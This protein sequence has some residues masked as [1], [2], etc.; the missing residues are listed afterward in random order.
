MADLATGGAQLVW[1]AP[2]CPFRIEYSARVLDDIRLAVVDAFF[3]LPRGGAEIGGILLGRHEPDRLII[4]SYQPIECEH[5]T[6]PSFTLSR[7]DEAKLREQLVSA[8]GEVLGWYHSHTRSE[9]FLSD[10]DLEVHKRFF[11]EAWQI[12]IVMKPHTFQPMRVGIF[13]QERDGTIQASAPYS[14][15][16]LEPLPIRQVP[17]GEPPFQPP[18][19][20]P[21]RIEPEGRGPAGPI[22]DLALPKEEPARVEPVGRPVLV[23]PPEPPPPMPVAPIPVTAAPPPPTPVPPTPVPPIPVPPTAA[24]PIPVPPEPVIAAPAEVAPPPETAAAVIPPPSFLTTQPEPGH[25]PRWLALLAILA[26]L[27]LGGVGYLTHEAWWPRV[28]KSVK[29]ALPAS[30]PPPTFGLNTLDTNGQLQIHWDQGSAATR[31]GTAA[32]LTITDGSQQPVSTPLDPQHLQAGTFTYA[33]QAGKVEVKMTIRLPDGRDA[34]EATTFLGAMPVVQPPP[35]DP[36]VR[37]Q[38]DELA[39]QAQKLKSDLAAQER[40]TKKLE[41]SLTDVQRTLRQEQLRRMQNQAP[42]K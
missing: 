29:S 30:A 8:R 35:E 19:G 41:R 39:A 14:E 40:R 24:A 20:S 16:L 15:M 5:A 12:A 31:T 18:I 10:A 2:Q 13:F 21:F 34:T 9:L 32:T 36:E 37:R 23:K 22:I 26:G 42:P 25:A 27:A 3:S 17:S 33:R 7:N 11:P 6:G 1:E 28:S 38:R 4:N